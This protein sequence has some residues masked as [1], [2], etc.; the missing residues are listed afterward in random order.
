MFLWVCLC[1]CTLVSTSL[2]QAGSHSQGPSLK[3]DLVSLLG[4][5]L[6][7]LFAYS[8]PWV[9]GETQAVGS[10]CLPP[11]LP[12]PCHY[13]E[14]VRGE[15]SCSHNVSAPNRQRL[16]SPQKVLVEQLS[17][18]YQLLRMG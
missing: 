17:F 16:A 4:L 13:L 9:W 12:C 2:G 6:S 8:S 18:I 5:S 7:P 10:A 1:V 3:A 14:Q 15:V 11:S